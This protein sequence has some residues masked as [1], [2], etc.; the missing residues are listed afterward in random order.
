MVVTSEDKELVGT[1]PFTMEDREYKVA[2]NG[3]EVN[4]MCA[5]DALA[6]SLMF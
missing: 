6:V 1:Y 5:I 2:I 4:A 3:N